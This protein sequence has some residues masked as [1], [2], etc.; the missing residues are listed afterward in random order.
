MLINN[1]QQHIPEVK[2]VLSCIHIMAAV[3]A[4]VIVDAV[5]VV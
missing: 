1:P 2:L 3:E 5:E 4:D